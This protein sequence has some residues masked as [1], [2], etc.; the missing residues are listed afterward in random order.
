MSSV[1]VTLELVKAASQ[2]ELLMIVTPASWSRSGVG[3]S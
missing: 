2:S 1:N 3:P